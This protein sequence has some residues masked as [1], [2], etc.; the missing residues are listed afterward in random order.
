M[1]S[2]GP[3][4]TLKLKAL[5]KAKKKI[6]IYLQKICTQMKHSPFDGHT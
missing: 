4:K 6:W 5:S 2:Q 1:G 3:E